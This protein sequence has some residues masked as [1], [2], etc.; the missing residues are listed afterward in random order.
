MKI[1]IEADGSDY[2]KRMLA[3]V[4]SHDEWLGSRHQH[5]VVHCILA[6]THRAAA[7]VGRTVGRE[8]YEEDAEAALGQQTG[9]LA[10]AWPTARLSFPARRSRCSP[11]GYRQGL[12]SFR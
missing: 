2:T 11:L 12:C 8:C 5:T 10:V 3:H 4:A 6:A 9:W 7:F 1:L